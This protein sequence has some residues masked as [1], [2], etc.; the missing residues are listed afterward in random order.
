MLKDVDVKVVRGIVNAVGERGVDWLYPD[1]WRDYGGYAQSEF[2]GTCQNLLNDGSP[3][4]I[5]GFIAVD[6][7]LPTFQETNAT[8]DAELWNDSHSIGDAMLA[9]QK[10]QDDRLSW[11]RAGEAFFAKLSE[12]TEMSVDE[13]CVA[14]DVVRPEWL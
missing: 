5:I 11:G 12:A 8:S 14:A 7:G 13:I 6:Q 4:C 3:A 9:A 1:E 10:V 2:G